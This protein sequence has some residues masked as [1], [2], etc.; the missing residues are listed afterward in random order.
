[1]KLLA[2]LYDPSEGRILLDGHD[3]REYDLDALRGGMGVIFQDFVRYNL[4][5]GRQYRGGADRGAP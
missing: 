2:R 4:S 5:G 3:L 1:M